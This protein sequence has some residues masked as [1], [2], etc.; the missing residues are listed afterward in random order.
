MFLELLSVAILGGK[1]IN[2]KIEQNRPYYGTERDSFR[3][4]PRVQKER[5]GTKRLTTD[6]LNGVSPEERQRRRMLGYYD[7]ENVSVGTL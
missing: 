7:G 4:N 6:I 2:E 3:N 1:I 5:I